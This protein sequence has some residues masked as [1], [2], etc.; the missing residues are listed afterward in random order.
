MSRTNPTAPCNTQS[1]V[2][3]APT[4]SSCKPSKRMRCA[5]DV[6][7]VPTLRPLRPLGQHRLEIGGRLRQCHTIAQPSDE[8]QEMATAIAGV[9]RIECQRQP[10]QNALIVHVVA[11]RHDADDAS[12]CAVDRDRS[13]DHRLVAGKSALPDLAREHRDVFGT[14]QRVLS[15]ELASAN[16]RDTEDRHQLRGDDGGIHTARLIRRSKVD[17]SRSVGAD[18][19]KRSVALGELDELRRR[20]PE[21]VEAK[22]GELAR[23]EDQALGRRVRQRLEDDAVDDAEDRGVGANPERQRQNRHGGVARALAQAA[24]GI[25]EILAHRNS[26]S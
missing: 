13:A 15:C 19:L 8:I 18:L 26:L 14:G 17:R 21:L 3:R 10:H 25:H 9:G 23:D 5:L 11:R 16:R 2:R 7:H 1:A 24:K 22:R 6:R 4:R 12:R 20:N